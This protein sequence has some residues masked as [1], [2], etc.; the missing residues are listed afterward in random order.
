MK[1]NLASFQLDAII[2]WRARVIRL[3]FWNFLYI[4]N[5][6]LPF[7]KKAS[8]SSCFSIKELFDDR[9]E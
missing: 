4:E 8:L 1:M 5:Y 7:R 2:S 9:G 3:T 6:L